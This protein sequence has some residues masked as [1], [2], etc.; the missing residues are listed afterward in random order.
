MLDAFSCLLLPKLCW[1]NWLKP[2]HCLLLQRDLVG[3]NNT[4]DYKIEKFLA[5]LANCK[6]YAR[7]FLSKILL[8]KS[9]AS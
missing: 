5:N 7:I 8:P 2:S 9:L 3:R 1:H 6:R 4:V